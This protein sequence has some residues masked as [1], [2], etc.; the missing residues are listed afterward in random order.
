MTFNC[1]VKGGKYRVHRKSQMQEGARLDFHPETFALTH[2]PNGQGWNATFWYAWPEFGNS[3][4]V[5]TYELRK[6]DSMEQGTREYWQNDII[7]IGG[8]QHQSD[9]DNEWECGTWYLKRV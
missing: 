4:D 7:P 1:P 3:L 9:G 2:V 6:R 8:F 5:A